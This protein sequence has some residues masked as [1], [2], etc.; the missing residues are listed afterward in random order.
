MK[1]YIP[2]IFICLLIIT[3]GLVIY[4]RLGNY[5]YIL[6]D[7]MSSIYD[8]FLTSG[9]SLEKIIRTFSDPP[10]HLPYRV[11]VPTLVRLVL[12]EF[13]GGNAG[14][15]HLFSLYLHLV[16]ALLLFILLRLTTGK[17]VESGFCA[18]L[19]T[20]HPVNVEAV[21]WLA[22][23]NGLLEAFFLILCLICYAVYVRKPSLSRYLLIFPPFILGLMSKP[24]M[25]V[26]PFLMILFDFWPLARFSL[27]RT[28]LKQIFTGILHNRIILEK[29]PLLVLVPLQMGLGDL[30]ATGRVM[31]TGPASLRLYPGS[32]VDFFFHLKKVVFPAGLTIGRPDP[33]EATFLAAAGV[34]MI[35]LLISVIILWRANSHR[36]LVTGWFWFLTAASPA[37]LVLAL[38][39][40]PVEDHHLYI[41]LIGLFIMVVFGL[42]AII[43]KRG[44]GRGFFLIPAVIVVNLLAVVSYH[45]VGYWRDSL[46][47]FSHALDVYPDNKK[48]LVILG[49]AYM[50]EDRGEQARRCYRQFLMFAP[51]SALGH[52]KLA[53]ALAAAGQTST[54]VRHYRK[55]MALSPD[56]APAYHDLA[57]LM[58]DMGK[59]DQAIA[60]YRK[61]L[62]INPDLFQTHN[63]LALALFKRGF[64]REACDHLNLALKINP[65]YQ[66]AAGNLQIILDATGKRGNKTRP[67][68]IGNSEQE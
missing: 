40:R 20:V 45:Q 21:S 67:A 49:D 8:P 50:K 68:G 17:T 24:S 1:K 9:I 16:I 29:I 57:D 60:L 6:Y 22:G 56:Y 10:A 55:A 51:D 53:D 3:A 48:A 65:A 19:F 7:D 42:S 36:Y 23:F 47:V 63:N 33:P 64:F 15:H 18:L 62:N 37:A 61:A 34:I 11:P 46:T 32:L 25:V 54:A 52:T 31:H 35:I 26:V 39:G 44:Y 41:P 12:W 28:G 30:L 38:S 14:G 27:R 43:S 2:D 58:M 13:V 5:D 59:T 66:T 4:A